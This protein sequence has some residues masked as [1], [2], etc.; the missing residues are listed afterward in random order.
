MK[1]WDRLYNKYG[2]IFIDITGGEPFLY[3]DF[4]SLVASLCR[5]HIVR[6]TTNLSYPLD[7]FIKLAEPNNVLVIASFHP[8]FAKLDSFIDKC[9]LLKKNNFSIDVSY[10]AYP[11]QLDSIPL[12]SNLFSKENIAFRVTAFWGSY[13]GKN[14]PDSYTYVE[15]SLVKQYIHNEDRIKYNLNKVSIKGKY[16]RAGE[17]YA[18]IRGDGRV[19]RCGRFLDEEIGSIFAGTFEFLEEPQICEVEYCPCSEYVAC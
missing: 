1:H 15:H 7:S 13:E 19:N 10:V 18:I 6:I 9:I 17:A 3:P 8:L 16:C 2:P 11:K 14:Y 4:V 12:Y 5:K